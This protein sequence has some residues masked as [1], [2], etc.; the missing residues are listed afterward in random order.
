MSPDGLHHGLPGVLKELDYNGQ[1]YPFG[2][3]LYLLHE[4]KIG[5]EICEDA[6]VGDRRPACRLFEQGVQLV[7]NP[8]ASH[9]AFK[10]SAFREN[11]VIESSRAFNCVYIYSNLLGNE[12]G[13]MIFDGDIFIAQEG[14]LVQRNV[15]LSYTNKL[16]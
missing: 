16:T 13:R 9:F 7:L 10:K 11:L 14:R 2:D 6:W 3:Q 4:I 1:T 5:F 15:K 12:T 8:S